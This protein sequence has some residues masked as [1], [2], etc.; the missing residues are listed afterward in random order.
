MNALRAEAEL[1]AKTKDATTS[2]CGVSQQPKGVQGTQQQSASG[3]KRKRQIRKR[4]KKKCAAGQQEQGSGSK[5][6]Q[7][8]CFK[9][10]KPDHMIAQCLEWNNPELAESSDDDTVQPDRKRCRLAN[11][12]QYSTWMS[13]RYEAM[14]DYLVTSRSFITSS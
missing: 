6:D 13:D 5:K 9:C 8:L 2:I 1:D 12:L 10:H 7:R 3:Q 11:R 14:R 4:S